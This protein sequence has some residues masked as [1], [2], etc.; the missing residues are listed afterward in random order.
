VAIAAL[1][2]TIVLFF[3]WPKLAHDLLSSAYM[4][5]MPHLY[6]YLG[7]TPLAWTHVIADSLIGLAYL[8]IS[9]TLAYLLYRGRGD[10]PFHVLFL[11][12]AVFI[13]ACGSSHMVE[14]VTVWIPIYVLSAT[15][16]VVTA[17]ASL[18]TALML[19]FVVPEVL[20]LLQTAR[21]SEARRVLLEAVLVERDAAQRALKQSNTV[22]EQRVLE[23]T[24]QITRAKEGLEAE[25]ME[26]RRN[27]EL[28][29]QSE[30]RFSKAFRSN[31]LALTISTEGEGRYLDVNQAFLQLLGYTRQ[32]VIGST[33]SELHFWARPSQRIEM[34]RQLGENGMVTGLRAQYAT[35][36]GE[37][38]EA[39]VSAE[40]IELE[41]Q[42]CVL[43]IT[44]DITEAQRLEAQFRQAQKMEAVGRLVGGVD[45]DFNNIL[46]VIIG[47]SDLSLD[48]VAPGSPVNKQ[49]EQ[50]KKASQPNDFLIVDKILGQAAP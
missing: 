42:P 7:S 6:C 12:F 14:A 45:H 29:R 27:E 22:L 18:A 3:T 8:A 2:A 36:K 5:H 38:R 40:L 34:L 1:A 23:R 24:A 50:I 11:A 47:Y 35:S 31:P 13:I 44:R 37:I 15:I 19:P 39:D 48:L 41:G 25:V 30:E 9:G 20:S 32:E 26:R 16:K 33:A 49:L 43:A 28:L 4:P 46:S 17:I 21:S 10:L